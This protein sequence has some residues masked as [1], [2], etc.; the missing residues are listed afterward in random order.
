M[1]I[2][3]HESNSPEWSKWKWWLIRVVVV[4]VLCG[5]VWWFISRDTTETIIV[6]GIPWGIT[7]ALLVISL[8]L[9]ITTVPLMLL[10]AKISGHRQDD[11]RKEIADTKTS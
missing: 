8:I 4:S 10:V 9:G 3:I 1:V 7:L 6:L 11:K 2:P 5:G